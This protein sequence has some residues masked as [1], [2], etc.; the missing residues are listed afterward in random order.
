[1]SRPPATTGPLKP[2]PTS[3]SQTTGGPF[4]G[5]EH[6]RPVSGEWPS[7]VGRGPLVAGVPAVGRP[8]PD[9]AVHVVQAPGVRLLGADRRVVALRVALEPAVVADPGGAAEREVRFRAGAAGVLP[10]GLRRQADDL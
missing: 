2:S 10:L 7:R 4:A 5:K 9:V 6:T 3:R 8:L 1:M